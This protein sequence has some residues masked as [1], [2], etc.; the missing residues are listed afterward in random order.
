[1]AELTL[2]DIAKQVGVSRSTV[3][4]VVNGSPNVSA[5][6]RSKVLDAIQKTGYHPNAAARSLASQRTR[7]IGLVVPNSVNTF[8]NDPFFPKL[9]QGIAFG[10]NN[11]DLS[12]S[13]F[14]IGNKEDE[15]K[16]LPR[17][18]QSGMLDG[19]LI[20]SE[21]PGDPLVDYLTASKIPSVMLGRP[22]G[23]NEI[24]YVDVDNFD[25]AAKATQHLIDLG[26]QR[27]ATI[28]GKKGNAVTDDRLDG[29]L[30]ALN[31]SGRS[32]NN[33]LIATGDFTEVGGYSAMKTIQKAKP[34][35]VFI[36]SD[37]M[38]VGAI[39]YL[40]AINLR[41]PEDVAIV[42]FDDVLHESMIKIPLTTIRQPI[43][44]MGVKA[45][46][47]LIELIEKG[48]NPARHCVLET[49]LIIRDS[50]GAKIKQLAIEL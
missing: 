45:V 7:M 27:I 10:C 33:S 39:R 34:D 47:L 28:T 2:E 26:Y 19:V 11:H 12:L 1:M 14:L 3:S 38:A 30:K 16:I 32:I 9:I 21:F 24:S 43:K 36:T 15:E 35:A 22:K 29:Y 41:V 42:G 23:Q 25:A 5:K 31:E 49:E 48:K 40:Q 46:E 13:L 44:K 20:Q 37:L 4:R 50:C 18:S 8:F 6:V 17:I